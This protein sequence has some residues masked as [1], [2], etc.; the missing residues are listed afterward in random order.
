MTG[1]DL[2]YSIM[3]VSYFVHVLTF[4]NLYLLEGSGQSFP[5]RRNQPQLHS[6]FDF[7]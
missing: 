4:E 2:Q 7:P 1:C 3:G 6:R 5:W